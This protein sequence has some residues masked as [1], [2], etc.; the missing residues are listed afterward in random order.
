MEG[1]INWGMIGCGDVTEKKSAP[2]FSKIEGSALL[3]VTNR[4]RDRALAYAKR[5]GIQKVYEDADRLLADPELNAVY[6]ATPPSSHAD[7][8]IRAM[9][10]GKPVYVEKPMARTYE[11]CKEM[12]RVSAST[13]VPLFV[14]YYRRSMA[15]F[16]KVRELL[17]ANVIGKPVLCRLGLLMPPREEDRRREDPPWRVVPEI[18]GGGYFHDMGCHELDLLMYLFGEVD[19]AR[20]F[21]GN[22]GGLYKPPD[23]VIA[24]IRFE[25]GLLLEACWCFTAPAGSAF[26]EIEIVGE[27]GSLK[28]SC[29]TFTPI[30]LYNAEGSKVYRVEAEQHVQMPLI[31]S[32]VEEL[33]GRG[34]CPSTGITAARVSHLMEVILEDAEQEG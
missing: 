24:S 3:G 12:N 9:Q 16:L 33:Q 34:K 2:S 28:F 14:A 6:I 22:F 26:D 25:G 29:F 1:L 20:G 8:A 17:A 5:H 27:S 18:S 10:A 11:E 13:G 15:Y 4:T 31:R 21:S 30:E 23:T 19:S 32:V 7:Y